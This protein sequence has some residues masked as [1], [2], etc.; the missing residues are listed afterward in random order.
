MDQLEDTIVTSLRFPF[1]VTLNDPRTFHPRY[2]EIN[3]ETSSFNQMR[4]Q[5]GS[6]GILSFDPYVLK[7]LVLHLNSF[8]ILEWVHSNSIE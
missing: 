1:H 8:T 6:C 2:K 7:R 4:N 5:L 3:P